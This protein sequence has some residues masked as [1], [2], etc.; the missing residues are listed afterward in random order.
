MLAT[1][2]LGLFRRLSQP[3]R[4]NLVSQVDTN[5]A[6]TLLESDIQTGCTYQGNSLAGWQV[7]GAQDGFIP[8]DR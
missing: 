6:L 5:M 1:F 7:P 3:D 2:S 8:R 4:Q